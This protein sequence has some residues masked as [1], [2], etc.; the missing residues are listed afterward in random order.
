MARLY[1]RR[2]EYLSACQCIVRPAA[3]CADYYDKISISY[4]GEDY[5]T[6]CMLADIT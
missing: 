3:Y 5:F 2:E 4:N 6:A 1:N